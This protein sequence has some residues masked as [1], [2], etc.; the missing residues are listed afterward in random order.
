MLIPKGI[1]RVKSYRAPAIFDL[2]TTQPWIELDVLMLG[3]NNHSLLITNVHWRSQGG[4][5]WGQWKRVSHKSGHSV[6]VVGMEIITFRSWLLA[7]P[8]SGCLEWTLTSSCDF[9]GSWRKDLYYVSSRNIWQS[10]RKKLKRRSGTGTFFIRLL[11][12]KLLK[13]DWHIISKTI[14]ILNGGLIFK[15]T[16]LS[17]WT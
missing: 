8:S 10:W 12:L 16:R 2:C 14:S 6:E 9:K 11:V 13:R 1:L 5:L 15:K 4:G 17:E 7:K 3:S